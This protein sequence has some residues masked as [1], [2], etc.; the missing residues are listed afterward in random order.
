ML[1]SK[2]FPGFYFFVRRDASRL[3]VYPFLNKRDTMY[4][5][6]SEASF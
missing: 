1:S 4:Y 3:T 2:R 5:A 6:K